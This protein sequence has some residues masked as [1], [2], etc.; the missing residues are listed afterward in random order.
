LISIARPWGR[1]AGFDARQ[2]E[3]AAN[4]RFWSGIQV[5]AFAQEFSRP[6]QQRGGANPYAQDRRPSRRGPVNE[7]FV[8]GPGGGRRRRM[9]RG[10]LTSM[11]IVIVR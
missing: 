2:R 9:L 6:R 8:A 4:R 1:P 11:E 7:D 3:P 5:C 10:N